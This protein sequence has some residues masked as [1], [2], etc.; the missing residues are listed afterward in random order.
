VIGVKENLVDLV[1][2]QDR[3]SRPSEKVSI[4]PIEYAGKSFQDKIEELRKELDKKK[5]A[6]FVICT[7]LHDGR[8]L[9]MRKL[10]GICSNA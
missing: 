3:P 5:R 7:D 9:E 10:T 8:N 1:W 4:H 2:G 6:G